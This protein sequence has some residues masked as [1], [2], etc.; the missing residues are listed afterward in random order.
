MMKQQMTLV[1]IG[2]HVI[3]DPQERQSFLRDFAR[4]EGPKVLVHG[5][6]KLA[7]RLSERL[8]S[9]PRIVEGR[10][11]TDDR[12]LDVVTMVYAGLVN[13]QIVAALGALSCPAI[14]LCGADAN[15]VPAHLRP[16]TP[17][18]FGWVGDIEPEQIDARFIADLLAKGLTPVF[19]AITHDGGGHLLNTNA[20]SV[21]TAIALACSADFDTRLVF[22]LEKNG[23]LCNVDDPDSVISHISRDTFQQLRQQG[24]VNSGMLP[25]IEGAL[26][27]VEGGVGEV[28]IKH[29]RN[30]LTPIGTRITTQ[31]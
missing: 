25:K 17:V 31:G 11:I 20:D 9:E 3:D 29:A 8:G 30:L 24:I 5:G 12:T 1:K 2:G 23:V 16:K 10:R 14:G 7:T 22:C 13:K 6:G 26:K 4:M 19:S 27:A 21:A 15:V 18:D 28:V